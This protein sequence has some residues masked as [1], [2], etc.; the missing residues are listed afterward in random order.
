M[1]KLFLA[2]GWGETGNTARTPTPPSQRTFADKA[3]LPREIEK[4]LKNFSVEKANVPVRGHNA[5]E[6]ACR[7][8][9]PNK[10]PK[11][12]PTVFWR[13][14][15][16]AARRSACIAIRTSAKGDVKKRGE[17]HGKHSEEKNE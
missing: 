1:S 16:I 8:A 2:G 5:F 13:K 6:G 9:T 15:N 14:G 4:E 12:R 3:N 11:G 7:E 17:L 10:G